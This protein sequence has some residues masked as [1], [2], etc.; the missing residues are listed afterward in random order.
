MVSG[1]GVSGNFFLLFI[2]YVHGSESVECHFGIHDCFEIEF[3]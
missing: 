1:M 3:I 2:T